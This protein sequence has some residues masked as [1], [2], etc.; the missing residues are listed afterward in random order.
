MTIDA[1][2]YSGRNDNSQ[3]LYALRRVGATFFIVADVWTCRWITPLSL[4]LLLME[5]MMM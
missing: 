5:R 3:I 1:V 2:S 4:M